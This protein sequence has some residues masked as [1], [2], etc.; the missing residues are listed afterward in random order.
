MKLSKCTSFPKAF[1]T[2]NLYFPKSSLYSF[3]RI[4]IPKGDSH[5]TTFEINPYLLSL[6]AEDGVNYIFPGNYKISVGGCLPV[7][8]MVEECLSLSGFLLSLQ[9]SNVS[10]CNESPQC[11]GQRLLGNNLVKILILHT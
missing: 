4:N 5:T 10:S 6:V 2:L 9:S 3:E 7:D 8:S 1:L 11:L